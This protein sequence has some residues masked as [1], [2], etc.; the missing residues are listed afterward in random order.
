MADKTAVDYQQCANIY[1]RLQS[2][3]DQLNQV[4][5]TTKSQV[6]SLH[7]GAWIGRGSDKFFDD[8]EN[9][10]LPSMGRLVQALQT[11]ATV[12]SNIGSTFHN[13]EQEALAAFKKIR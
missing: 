4:L 5:S 2:E 8:M 9:K 12:L 3:A 6:E 7:G 10:V 1:K 11:T 13:A